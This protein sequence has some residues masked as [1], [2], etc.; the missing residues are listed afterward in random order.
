VGQGSV[1]FDPEQT[2]YIEGILK[3]AVIDESDRTLAE[4]ETAIIN[5]TGQGGLA[6]QTVKIKIV[7]LEGTYDLITITFPGSSVTTS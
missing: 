4:G 1:S 3:S 5:V 6:G 7:T 2:V